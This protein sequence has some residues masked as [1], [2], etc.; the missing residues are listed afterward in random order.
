MYVVKSKMKDLPT[1]IHLSQ[2]LAVALSFLLICG[3]LPA[4]DWRDDPDAE[5]ARAAAV[6]DALPLYR[7]LLA[8]YPDAADL[9]GEAGGAFYEAKSYEE[10]L[11]AYNSAAAN[12]WKPERVH[13][14]IGKSLEK[15]RRPSEAEAEFRKALALD[16]AAVA[17]QFGLGAALF[18]QNRSAEALPLFSAM[19]KRGDEWG[20]Y[21]REY[22]AYCRFDTGNYSGTIEIAK[23]LMAESPQDAALRWLLGRAL[24]KAKRFEEALSVFEEVIRKEPQRA[25]QA[26]YYAAVCLENLGRKTEAERIYTSIGSDLTEWGREARQSAQRLAGKPWR[27]VLDYVGGYDSNVLQGGEEERGTGKKDGFN[28]VYALAEGRVF[29]DG[30]TSVWVA[31][32]QFSLLY[33]KLHENDYVQHAARVSLFLPGVGPA[34]RFSL[35]YQLRYSE[36]DYQPYRLENRGQ[37]TAF[38]DTK[39][40]MLSVSLGGAANQYYRDSQNLSGPDAVIGVDYT[41]RLPLWEHLIR[42]RFL[43]EYRWTEN[44]SLE[45][46]SQRMRVQYRAQIWSIVYA[47]ME[48]GLRRD[49]F[50]NSGGLGLHRRIDLRPS[51]EIQ[52]D[53]QVHNNISINWGYLYETQSSSRKAQEFKRSQ[54]YAGFTLSF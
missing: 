23:S 45:R 33:P 18:N 37:L 9:Q 17:A 31:G 35:D 40:E 12:G 22:V 6:S 4:A 38:R 48:A 5:K 7:K 54:V 14:R 2:S 50:P 42:V 39:T 8:K 34:T 15:L 21:A 32:E 36:L 10:A 19:L 16:P 43:N 30:E 3:L 28:Q 44:K 13:I 25:V 52:F 51:G 47:Q 41:H 49:A 26:Q 11:V 1:G 53:A 27:F 20:K 46:L 29:Q 24:Y